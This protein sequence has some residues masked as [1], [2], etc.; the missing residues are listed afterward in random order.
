MRFGFGKN[1]KSY[2]L[3]LKPQ[4]I[5]E[6]RKAIVESLG[7]SDFSGLH[8]LD[9]GSGSGLSS[10][11]FL[12]MGADVT[13][14]DYDQDS[15]EC[16]IS[17][18]SERA[19]PAAKW[20]VSKGSVL[21]IEFMQSLR[22]FDLVYSWGV[23]HHTGAMW[24]SMDNAA[25]AVNDG[26]ILLI[27]LYNDQGSL[28]KFWKAVKQAYCSGWLGRSV[29]KALFYPIFFSYSLIKDF[30]NREIPM[31]HSRNYY[32]N[33]GMSIVHDWDDWLGGYPFEVASP[34]AVAAWAANRGLSI[35]ATRTT[36]GLGCNEF[37]FT[38]NKTRNGN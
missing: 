8:I 18:L 22:S 4:S 28:S 5:A 37:V 19:P 33:R 34:S 35:R 29:V 27:A 32:L 10:L 14:F 7:Q 26:G 21:D 13:A 11:A 6:S 12:E 36:N 15:V 17:L 30:K 2:I 31:S 23:L 24:Q 9:I 1:W 16:T 38:K 25:T 20:H 3:T